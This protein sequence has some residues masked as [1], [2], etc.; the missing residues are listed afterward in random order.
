MMMHTN[1]YHLALVALFLTGGSQEASAQG[2][3]KKVGS[4]INKGTKELEK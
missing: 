3:F 4:A 1:L 2:F